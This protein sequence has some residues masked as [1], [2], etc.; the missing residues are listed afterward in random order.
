ME[1]RTSGIAGQIAGKVLILRW[2]IEFLYDNITPKEHETE[3]D[4]GLELRGALRG[5]R[6]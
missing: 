1:S 6:G 2:R 3:I 4:I 5:C